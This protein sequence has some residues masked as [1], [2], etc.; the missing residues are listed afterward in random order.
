L[1][2]KLRLISCWADAGAARF[3][4]DLQRL[5]PRAEIQGKGLIATEGIVSFPLDLQGG[6]ALALRSH[7]FEFIE[8][9]SGRV[10]LAHEL[11]TGGRYSVVI[12]TGG[13]LYR[14]RLHDLV[15]IVGHRRGCP[16]LKFIGKEA[17]IS[18]RFGEKLNE[19]HVREV[20][21]RCAERYEASPDFA[22]LACEER[23]GHFAY[24]LFVEC[25]DVSEYTLHR[26]GRDLEEGLLDNFHYRYCRDLGQ[27]DPVRVFRIRVGGREAYLEHC[28]SLGQRLGEI[29]PSALHRLSGWTQVFQGDWLVGERE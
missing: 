23:D 8:P 14:Y 1:W 11:E 28:R 16:L 12:T 29:K 9:D 4:P 10:R 5:F 20:L 7:F 25:R 6:A 26:I 24:T 21:D 15:E 13:G 18:D 22:M 17:H 27:L 19:R 2:P 3:I